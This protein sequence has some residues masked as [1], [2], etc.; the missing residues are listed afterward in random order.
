MKFHDDYDTYNFV[1]IFIV[2]IFFSYPL[3]ILISKQVDN[4]GNDMKQGRQELG[5]ISEIL[6]VIPQ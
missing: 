6:E 5:G 3:Y 1:F 2:H 4:N